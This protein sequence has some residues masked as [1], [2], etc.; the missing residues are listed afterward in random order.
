MIFVW[1]GNEEVME[2]LTVNVLIPLWVLLLMVVCMIP[3]LFMVLRW[4]RG[5]GFVKDKEIVVIGREMKFVEPKTKKEPEKK[6][7]RV[8]EA[9]ILKLL[10]VKGD[11]GMLVQSIA[12]F[13]KIDSNATNHAL[14]YLMEKKMVEVVTAMGGNKYFLSNAGKKY[15]VKKGYIRTAAW[16]FIIQDT[17][18]ARSNTFAGHARQIHLY[19]QSHPD[20]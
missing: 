1:I 19:Q 12:D 11:Q 16:Q 5:K 15:C 4:L 10:A 13:L 3:F 6:N 17:A 20:K 7:K 2:Y 14:K 8:N 18:I 9:K